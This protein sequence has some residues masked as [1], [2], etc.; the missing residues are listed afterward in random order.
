M[1]PTSGELTALVDA[2]QSFIGHE[3]AITEHISRFRSGGYDRHHT[4]MSRFRFL[5]DAFVGIS[6]SGELLGIESKGG[7]NFYCVSLRSIT[8]FHWEK[9]DFVIVEHFEEKTA[10]LTAIQ[11]LGQD[12]S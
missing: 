10:R 12:E 6:I 7:A 2:L 4:T 5:V 3:V 11:K 8:E 9:G 1:K